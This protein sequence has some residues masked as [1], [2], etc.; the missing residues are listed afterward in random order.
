M[1]GNHNILVQCTTFIFSWFMAF[2]TTLEIPYL[3]TQKG[4]IYGSCHQLYIFSFFTLFLQSLSIRKHFNQML[5]RSLRSRMGLCYC[6]GTTTM[7]T[8]PKSC[9]F[10]HWRRPL[11]LIVNIRKKL[12]DMKRKLIFLSCV[13]GTQI[14]SVTVYNI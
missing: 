6:P 5:V 8:S 2:N 3:A 9:S 11:L 4:P 1:S 13:W 10:A 14:I 12:Q 7:T